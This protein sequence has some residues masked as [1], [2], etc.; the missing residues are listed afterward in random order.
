MVTLS[1]YSDIEGGYVDSGRGDDA[2]RMGTV[3]NVSVFWKFREENGASR[4]G[5]RVPMRR[6]RRG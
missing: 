1:H 6:G 5:R 2:E 4:K 3:C